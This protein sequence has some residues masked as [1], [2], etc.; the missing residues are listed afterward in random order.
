MTSD[1]T[2]EA[3]QRLRTTIA[4]EV[5]HWSEDFHPGCGCT[6]HA[7]LEGAPHE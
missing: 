7:A 1:P 5:M 3:L 2:R 4:G 6:C